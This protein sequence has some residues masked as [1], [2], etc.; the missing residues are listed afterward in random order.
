[1]KSKIQI[2]IVIA[3]LLSLSFY[4]QNIQA[5][6][7]ASSAYKIQTIFMY[8]FSKYIEW[9]AE[10]SQGEFV[11][12]IIGPEE[13]VKEVENMANIKS[14]EGRKFVVKQIS[15]PAEADQLHILLISSK[16]DQHIPA[17]VARYEGSPTLVVSQ[18]DNALAMGS[19]VNFLVNAQGKMQYELNEDRIKGKG[20]KIASS[21]LSL[22]TNR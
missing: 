7:Y 9:P 17:A 11:I 5:Q 1:M 4:C 13:L 3:V 18:S 19:C 20:L 22:A 6:G 14:T 12:G 21:L 8:N 16:D 15:S 2:R 10:T